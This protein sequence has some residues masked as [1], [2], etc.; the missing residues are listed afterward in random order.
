MVGDLKNSGFLGVSRY[1]GT[2]VSATGGLTSVDTNDAAGN[3]INALLVAGNTAGSS[4]TLDVKIQ[5]SSD[6]STW[7]DVAGATFTQVTTSTTAAERVLVKSAKRYL[8]AH[9]TIGGSSSPAYQVA[10]VFL[11]TDK[12][13]GTGG[14]WS[15]SAAGSY[16]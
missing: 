15:G 4:P 16:L 13:T 8:R 10:L 12:F 9:A 2:A 6:D 3:V 14:G 5:E 7:T 11:A 1:P